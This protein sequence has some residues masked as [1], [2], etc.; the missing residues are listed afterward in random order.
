MILA[1]HQCLSKSLIE[2][3]A[4]NWIWP[5]ME[6]LKVLIHP[7]SSKGCSPRIWTYFGERSLDTPHQTFSLLICPFNCLGIKFWISKFQIFHSPSLV[8]RARDPLGSSSPYFGM[9][10]EDQSLWNGSLCRNLKQRFSFFVAE[11]WSILIFYSISSR[12]P[13]VHAKATH[14]RKSI[15]V[16][17][18]NLSCFD[19]W[20][21]WG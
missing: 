1:L 3:L 15:R 19:K 12:F 8:P 10:W 4:L 7:V 18:W 20:R 6:R 9:D 2:K 14:S 17:F 11:R 13:L 16:L 5:E 21:I